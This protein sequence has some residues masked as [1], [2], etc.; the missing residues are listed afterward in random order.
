ML[1]LWKRVQ[2]W[3]PG[4]GAVQ[5]TSLP[6]WECQPGSLRIPDLIRGG[7][8]RKHRHSSRT[9]RRSGDWVP[10]GESPP[11]EPLQGCGVVAEKQQKSVM[12]TSVPFCPCKPAPLRFLRYCRLARPLPCLGVGA[13]P[14]PEIQNR[15]GVAGFYLVRR[16]FPPSSL[17][18]S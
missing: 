10:D 9:D 12:E 2:P 14:T 18:M 3:V 13:A 17:Q 11:G 4:E 6:S 16:L 5:N 15:V 8:K 7:T 1:I